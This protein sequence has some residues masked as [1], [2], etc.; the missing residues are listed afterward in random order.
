[1]EPRRLARAGQELIT[2]NLSAFRREQELKDSRDM[3][4]RSVSQRMTVYRELARVG[5]AITVN[6]DNGKRVKQPINVRSIDIGIGT[7]EGD[8]DIYAVVSNLYNRS[9]KEEEWSP[10]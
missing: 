9:V 3:L 4:E 1:M 8:Y 2:E 7:P 5:V 10:E 6:L